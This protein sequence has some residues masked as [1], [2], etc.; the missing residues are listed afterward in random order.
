[1]LSWLIVL[2]N[3]PHSQQDYPT[4]YAFA[5]IGLSISTFCQGHK[6]LSHSDYGKQLPTIGTEPLTKSKLCEGLH[7]SVAAPPPPTE[8]NDAAGG[9]LWQWQAPKQMVLEEIAPRDASFQ[10][11]AKKKGKKVQVTCPSLFNLNPDR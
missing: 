2:T 4:K 1:M 9:G 3:A 10:E 7:N 6:A 5:Q 11:D 8:L